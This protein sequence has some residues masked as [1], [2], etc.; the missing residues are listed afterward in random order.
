MTVIRSLDLF[1]TWQR[2]LRDSSDEP[3]NYAF[4]KNREV[5]SVNYHGSTRN[6]K[7]I[8]DKSPHKTSFDTEIFWNGQL[9][10]Q[11]K[12]ADDGKLFFNNFRL[13][14]DSGKTVN[15]AYYSGNSSVRVTNNTDCNKD[16]SDKKTN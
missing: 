16:K 13:G 8:L 3:L 9:K 15:D 6:I 1:H 4:I 12:R 7:K 5:E 14:L 11:I 10:L 2:E